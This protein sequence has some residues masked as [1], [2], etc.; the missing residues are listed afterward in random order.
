M[1]WYYRTV[2][3]LP[4]RCNNE[5]LAAR[6]LCVLHGFNY[7]YETRNTGVSFPLWCNETV[8]K[9]VSFV[10]TNKMELDLLL[11]QEYFVQM[12]KLQY[13][14][15]S[16]TI[17]VPEGCRYVSFKRC[18]SIDKVTTAGHERKIRRLEKRAKSRGEPFDPSSFTPKE[19]TVLSHYYS[20]EEF[21]SKTNNNF[22]LNVRMFSEQHNEGDSVFSS[23]GLS[24]S[25]HSLQPVPLI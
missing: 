1:N 22:R 24:N 15:I 23:Y 6:C 2:T 21:S 7:R 5:S 9:K 14:S 13:F 3:F 25:E 11:K 8:G 17:L 20:L 16:K 18:Q 10:S 12:K 4:E 19:H